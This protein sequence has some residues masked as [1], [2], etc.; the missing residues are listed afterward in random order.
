[1]QPKSWERNGIK[2]Q[3]PGTYQVEWMLL[4]S[5]N[6]LGNLPTLLIEWLESLCLWQG[7]VSTTKEQAKLFRRDKNDD[8]AVQ[9]VWG[10]DLERALQESGAEISDTVSLVNLGRQPVEA[11]RNIIDD[12]GRV[13]GSEKSRHIEM[14]GKVSVLEMG[15]RTSSE[16]LA[17]QS[18]K[19][20]RKCADSTYLF[21]RTVR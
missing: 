20:K 11:K 5:I 10:V 14:S 2:K 13:I 12:Q 9:T 7:T 6:G 18:T 4:L 3:N 16:A 1:M 21:S 19:L 17:D 8:G 15:S